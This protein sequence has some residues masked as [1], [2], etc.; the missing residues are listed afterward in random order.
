AWALVVYGLAHGGAPARW[1]SPRPLVR[2]GDASYGLYILHFP[3]FDTARTVLA[4][5]GEHTPPLVL[6]LTFAMLLPIS[7]LSFE[8]V[9]QPLR[10]IVLARMGLGKPPQPAASQ[11]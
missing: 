5:A 7:V 6:M 1:L 3:M 10:R 9:E 11:P 4:R 2:L 8:Q